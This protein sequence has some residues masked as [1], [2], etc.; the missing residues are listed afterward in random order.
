MSQAIVFVGGIHGAGKT[1]VSRRLAAALSASHVTAGALIREAAHSETITTGIGNK[2][3]GD[4]NA[5]QALL[6]QGLARYRR[7]ASGPIVLDGHFCLM[8]PGGDVVVIPT[9]VYVAIAPIAVAL[10]ESD[11]RIVHSRLLQRDGAA[12]SLEIISSLSSCERAQAQAVSTALKVP[13]FPVRGDISADE[14]A[15]T[16]ASAILPLLRGAV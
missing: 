15:Q 9:T 4:V 3:V 16:A 6:L 13:L 1:T 11:L 10:I 2:A 5:N 14:A 12:P 7:R 8:E